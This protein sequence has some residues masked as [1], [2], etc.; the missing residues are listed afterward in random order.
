[1]KK[2]F[3]I[4]LVALFTAC[5]GDD[6]KAEEMQPETPLT[7]SAN[8][9]GF[10]RSFGS[11]LNNYYL[12]K[13]GLVATNDTIANTYA[14]MLVSSADSISLAELKADSSIV[15]MANGYLQSIVAEA[16]ALT[17]VKGIEEKRKS[18]QMISDNMYNLV[19]TIRYDQEKIYYQYCPM[20]F[21]DAGAHWL[22]NSDE[23]RNPYFGKKMLVCGEVKDSIDFGK[24]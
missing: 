7:Q 1:M 11:F 3:A 6:K 18:F 12:L 10:N 9:E 15:E 20:A 14:K 24:K 23:I 5:A 8:P 21:N 13:D 2:F 19:R 22:S 16:K 4:A 17:L